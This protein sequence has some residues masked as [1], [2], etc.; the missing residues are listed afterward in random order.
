MTRIDPIEA[1]RVASD[2]W[3][4]LCD[5]TVTTFRDLLSALSMNLGGE[6]HPG[7][8]KRRAAEAPAL[9]TPIA[10]IRQFQRASRNWNEF[11]NI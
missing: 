3:A 4:L 9:E 2:G 5:P 8:A 7:I 6:D 10:M 1:G 11:S